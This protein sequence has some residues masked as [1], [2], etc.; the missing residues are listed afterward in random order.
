M[1]GYTFVHKYVYRFYS[2]VFGLQ[3]ACTR[4]PNLACA[5]LKCTCGAQF[6]CVHESNARVRNEKYVMPCRALAARVFCQV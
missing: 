1:R 4:N 5:F 3:F 2:A 6:Y